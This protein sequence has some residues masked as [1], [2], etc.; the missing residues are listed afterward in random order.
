MGLQAWSTTPSLIFCITASNVF[1]LKPSSVN[2]FLQ[3]TTRGGDQHSLLTV[4]F[5]CLFFLSW[6]VHLY[7]SLNYSS[8]DIIYTF[9]SNLSFTNTKWSIVTCLLFPQS[10]F[11][12]LKCMARNSISH[13][14]LMWQLLWKPRSD[15]VL[16]RFFSILKL[17]ISLHV[18]TFLTSWLNS[19]TT[20]TLKCPKIF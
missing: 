2:S 3:V 4:D 12:Q 14:Y 6:V 15:G 11:I 13:I 1:F 10:P 9:W 18:L 5:L 17:A 8:Q 16:L 7:F 20:V 19:I